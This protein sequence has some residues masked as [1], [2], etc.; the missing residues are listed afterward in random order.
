MPV[1]HPRC[2]A[3]VQPCAATSH[4]HARHQPKGHFD[5]NINSTDSSSCGAAKAVMA[6][7]WRRRL[8]NAGLISV[9]V[10]SK[11]LDRRV[12]RAVNGRRDATSALHDKRP[13][14]RIDV[15]VAQQR[16]TTATAIA[17]AAAV[18]TATIAAT[19]T[20]MRLASTVLDSGSSSSTTT[21][22]T[23]TI[24]TAMATTTT[25]TVA[26]ITAAAAAA[27]INAAGQLSKRW[28]RK[29]LDSSGNRHEQRPTVVVADDHC[30]H[31]VPAVGLDADRWLR[32][33]RVRWRDQLRGVQRKLDEV[34][35]R[36]TVGQFAARCA[37]AAWRWHDGGTVV[38]T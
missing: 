34:R 14:W 33:G 23:T 35:G 12:G 13:A 26:I 3:P 25:T 7:R 9:E 10:T 11:A 27:V 1:R 30:G 17:V 2:S 5:G 24:A 19:T 6:G 15:S 4:A 16:P 37:P 28:Y 22:T 32:G 29:T 36:A 18:A 38:R 20:I 21:T 31:D 8:G